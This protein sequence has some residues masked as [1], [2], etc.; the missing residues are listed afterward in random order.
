MQ[1]SSHAIFDKCHSQL[2]LLCDLLGGQVRLLALGLRELASGAR[3]LDFVVRVRVIVH[4]R[5]LGDEFGQALSNNLKD[6]LW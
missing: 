4:V 2:G 5:R 6:L 1:A 3:Q